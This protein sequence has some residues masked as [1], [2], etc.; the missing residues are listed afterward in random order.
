MVYSD[1]GPRKILA[2]AIVVI[3]LSFF[4]Y[5]YFGDQISN[6]I[7]TQNFL[8]QVTNN[9]GQQTPLSAT[10][11]QYLESRNGTVSLAGIT[12]IEAFQD[13]CQ[14]EL[15]SS[16]LASTDDQQTL[17]E[18]LNSAFDIDGNAPSLIP[19]L[20]ID[21]TITFQ[22]S[23]A[24]SQTGTTTT[25]TTTSGTATTGTTSGTG[26]ST[27]DGENDVFLNNILSIMANHGASSNQ[28]SVLQQHNTTQNLLNALF[29][30]L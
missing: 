25:T 7:N 12:T 16:G 19:A 4:T 10:E 26:G 9:G 21:S 6:W 28:H 30:E 11:I 13:L 17:V 20:I 5:G 18:Y 24:G 15:A 23:T 3:G 1:S 22:N 2:V 27:G 8:S 29:D 14:Q